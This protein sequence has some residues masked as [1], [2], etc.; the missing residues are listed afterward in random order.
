M[1]YVYAESFAFHLQLH[2]LQLNVLSS[3]LRRIDTIFWLL[4]KARF[5]QV[6]EMLKITSITCILS[7]KSPY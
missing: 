1:V 3:S 2:D 7:L 6:K 4:E 5:Q